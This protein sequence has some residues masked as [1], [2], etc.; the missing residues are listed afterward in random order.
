VACRFL[1]QRSF[2]AGSELSNIGLISALTTTEGLR[3]ECLCSTQGTARLLHHEHVYIAKET[4]E[5]RK[6]GR[7]VL[8][9]RFSLINGRAISLALANERPPSWD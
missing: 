6:R 1:D 4:S 5:E 9:T 8:Y 7:A 3:H 2:E